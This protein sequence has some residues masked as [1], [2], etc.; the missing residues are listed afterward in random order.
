MPGQANL[1][2]LATLPEQGK[3]DGD[4]DGGKHCKNGNGTI[5][6]V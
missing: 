2:R 1:V 4:N 6:P 3:Y 5:L